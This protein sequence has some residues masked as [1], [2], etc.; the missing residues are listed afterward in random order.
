MALFDNGSQWKHKYKLQNLHTQHD[1][2]QDNAGS[3][4]QPAQIFN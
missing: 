4:A 1:N 3:T 2:A